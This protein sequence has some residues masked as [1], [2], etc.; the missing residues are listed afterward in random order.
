[1]K[2][3]K[4]TAGSLVCL[5]MV[6]ALVVAK[7][8]DQRP[9]GLRMSAT[10]EKF[11]MSLP[12]EQRALATFAYDDAERLNWHFIPRPRK[13]LPLKAITPASRAAAHELISSGLSHNGYEQAIN[14][15][16]LDDVLYLVEK[17]DS[18][19]RRQRRDPLNYY[20]TIFGTPSDH[21]VW[22]WRL[23][24]HHLSLNYTVAD[25]RVTATTPEFFGANPADIAAGPGR[26]IRVLGVEEDLAREIVRAGDPEQQKMVVI[27]SKAPDDIPGG[28]RPQPEPFAPV[29]LPAAKMSKDQQALLKQL[30]GEYLRNMPDDVRAEREAKVESGAFDE[31]R[32]AW[33]GSLNRNERHAYRVQGPTFVIEYNNT[34]NNANHV[35]SVWRSLAG[36][37]N[38]PAKTK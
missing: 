6:G 4:L 20:L 34:Q 14:I 9:S 1:M 36:D 25:G 37:F 7:T 32:F 12:D 3:R 19:E 18:T 22:G 16:S 30:L 17:G 29:G 26:S 11:L 38:L 10:A 15:M 23:E 8:S 13:G 21:G 27:N 31:I 28:G 2:T 24:G 35:H 33:W 5:T